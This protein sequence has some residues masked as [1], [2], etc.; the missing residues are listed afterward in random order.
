MKFKETEQ[1]EKVQNDKPF[2]EVQRVGNDF[3]SFRGK[4]YKPAYKSRVQGGKLDLPRDFERTKLGAKV[5]EN[6]LQ[7]ASKVREIFVE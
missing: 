3:S 7:S 2:P 5:D 6:Q 1:F 4:I